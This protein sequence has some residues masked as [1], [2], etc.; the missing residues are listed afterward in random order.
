MIEL[1]IEHD[2]LVC[3]TDEWIEGR[4]SGPNQEAE[5][6]WRHAE[7]NG[8]TI[9]GWLAKIGATGL[10]DEGSASMVLTYN[11]DNFLD[12]DLAII[13]AHTERFGDLFICSYADAYGPSGY[14][15]FG[16]FNGD[17]DADAY[18]YTSGYADC[19][20]QVH[21]RSNQGD[22]WP[23]GGCDAEW[24][25]EAGGCYLYSNGGRGGMYDDG[26]V[27]TAD[28][29]LQSEET[30]EGYAICPRCRYGNLIFWAA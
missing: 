7:D 17:D 23:Y 3:D 25:L 15:H 14:W 21:N 27:R 22:T 24:I 10:Y 13:L 30:G 28:I 8:L 2:Y 29:L 20:C 19:T 18:G 6:A 4:I 16:N 26:K 1:K 9:E 12:R 11:E 5:R